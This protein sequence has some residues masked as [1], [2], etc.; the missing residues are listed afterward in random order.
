MTSYA[1][2]LYFGCILAPL[3]LLYWYGPELGG[4][5]MWA[6]TEPAD[7]CGLLTGVPAAHWRGAG[8]EGAGVARG[9]Q[10]PLH[11]ASEVGYFKIL[12]LADEAYVDRARC[13][14]EGAAALRPTTP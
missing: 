8:S 7:A 4:Y 12:K 2:R 10:P 13:D 1:A 11:H 9:R 5:G 3:H 6:G 14:P